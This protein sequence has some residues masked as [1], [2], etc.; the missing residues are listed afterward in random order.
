MHVTS[1][2]PP[3]PLRT[4]LRRACGRRAC[5]VEPPAITR[6]Q[7]RVWIKMTFRDTAPSTIR[8]HD[9]AGGPSYSAEE[10]EAAVSVAD[11]QPGSPQMAGSRI[12][13]HSVTPVH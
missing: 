1:W 6:H 4:G 12:E 8:T 10:N 13:P 2:L 5:W 3:L 9:P 11:P 7:F